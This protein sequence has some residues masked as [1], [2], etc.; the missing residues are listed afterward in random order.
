MVTDH[1]NREIDEIFKLCAPAQHQN[2]GLLLISTASLRWEYSEDEM[3]IALI[4][5]SPGIGFG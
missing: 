2:S 3:W 5:K 4:A 1:P